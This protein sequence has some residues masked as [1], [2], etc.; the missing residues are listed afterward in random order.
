MLGILGISLSISSLWPS[1]LVFLFHINDVNIVLWH[2][3]AVSLSC[4]TQGNK[5]GGGSIG[6]GSC[7]A[8]VGVRWMGG[9]IGWGVQSNGGQSPPTR[10]CIPWGCQE[11]LASLASRRGWGRFPP[12][13]TGCIT[14]EAWPCIPCLPKGLGFDGLASLRDARVAIEGGGSLPPAPDA[15]RGSIQHTALLGIFL[16]CFVALIVS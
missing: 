8:W 1:V 5:I 11:R 12:P 6:W 3:T 4:E 10:P 14:C 13:C 2:Q 15:R 16:I 9:L 7:F